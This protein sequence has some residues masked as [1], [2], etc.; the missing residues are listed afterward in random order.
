MKK[1]ISDILKEMKTNEFILRCG[2]PMGYV[3]GL[4]VLQ[5]RNDELCL[6]VPFLRY[7]VTG[8]PDKT[9]VYPIR[10]T[11]TFVL[12]EMKPVEF[13]DLQYQARF[14]KIS[15]G[16]PVGLFRHEAVRHLSRQEYQA[17]RSELMG[18]YDRVIDALLNDGEYGPEHEARMAELMTMMVEPSL[19][20]MY[21]A[22][23][24][25]F[26]GKYLL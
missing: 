11:A 24:A 9:L 10:Y 14:G 17:L 19:R 12:P 18:E 22:L 7:R 25:D 1:K 8:Q 15:F 5:I 13:Q 23:D 3:P 4:P 6:T 21:Q 2:M 26:Y 20:P 16:E